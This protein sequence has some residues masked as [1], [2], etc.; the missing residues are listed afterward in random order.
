M[1]SS[2][3]IRSPIAPIQV[4]MPPIAETTVGSGDDMILDADR[5]GE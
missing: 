4:G 3:P 2:P 1:A 5:L